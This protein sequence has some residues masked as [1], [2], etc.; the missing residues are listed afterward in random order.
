MI[1]PRRHGN[2]VPSHKTVHLIPFFQQEFREIGTVLPVY[3]RYQSHIIHIF[4]SPFR[5][6]AFRRQA[7]A[8]YNMPA[9]G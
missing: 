8:N 1:N 7:I 9:P 5:S 4:Y 2:A 3:S 6:I